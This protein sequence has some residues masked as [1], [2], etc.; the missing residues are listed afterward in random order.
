MVVVGDKVSA[1]RDG[2]VD[3]F[4][5]FLFLVSMFDNNVQAA[6]RTGDS[7]FTLG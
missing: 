7:S 4:S 2:P 1:A 5:S 3:A 6:Y